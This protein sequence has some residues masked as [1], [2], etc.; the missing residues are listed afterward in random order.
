MDIILPDPGRKRAE[1][2]AKIVLPHLHI[3]ALHDVYDRHKNGMTEYS[4]EMKKV[5][6]RRMK[7][8][9]IMEEEE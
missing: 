6:K 9:G 8:L 2:F 5:I 7:E 3:D 4:M 1:V